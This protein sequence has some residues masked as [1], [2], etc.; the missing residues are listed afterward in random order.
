MKFSII[1]NPYSKKSDA[2]EHAINFI[3]ALLV[4]EQ[5]IDNVF[6]YGY[7][8]KCAFFNDRRW[9]EIAK[10]NIV[11]SACSTIADDYQQPV[12][13]YF[14]L[15]GLGHWMETLLESHKRIEFV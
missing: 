13:P 3:H 9:K 1:I 4:E 6:F 14:K 8:V 10:H 2:V 12:L 5:S 7:A 15:R 11:L